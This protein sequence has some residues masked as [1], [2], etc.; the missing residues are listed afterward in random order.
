MLG[1]YY[2]Q[3]RENLKEQFAVNGTIKTFQGYKVGV[4]NFNAPALAKPVGRQIISIFKEKGIDIDFAVTWGYEYNNDMYRIQLIDDH[5]QTKI[6]IPSIAQ[7][8]G[9]VGGTS[10]G[11]FGHGHDGN[12]YWPH[13]DKKD[14]WDLFTH[15]YL[16]GSER[17]H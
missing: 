16:D 5:R 8:L 1:Y 14:I 17:L 15:N 10:K 13:S 3:M 2:D 7:Q 4:L 6:S 12:F 9:R 11:G